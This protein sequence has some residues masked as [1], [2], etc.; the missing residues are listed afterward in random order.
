MPLYDVSYATATKLKGP[1]TKSNVPLM[2]TNRPFQ[3]EAPGGASAINNGKNWQL[4]FHG[5]CPKGSYMFERVI[6]IEGT[7][8]SIS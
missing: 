1:Y 3:L 5:N 8:V 4:V 7:T 2:V 6:E